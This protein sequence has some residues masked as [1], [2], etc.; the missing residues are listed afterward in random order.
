MNREILERF[1]NN[2]ASEAEVEE[3]LKWFEDQELDPQKSQSLEE[4]WHE[5]DASD[6]V[7]HD[8]EQLLNDI[9]RDIRRSGVRHGDK[10]LYR[11]SRTSRR[12]DYGFATWAKA[13]AVLVVAVGLFVFWSVN[14]GDTGQTV[15]EIKK[16]TKVA[17]PGE[18][19]TLTLSD[20]TVIQLNSDS[21]IT[22]PEKFS[23]TEREV[24]LTGEAFFEVTEDSSRRFVVHTGELTTTVL[25]TSFNIRN[26][27]GDELTDISL[28][29][30]KLKVE[31]SD[32]SSAL[33]S[34]VLR[35]G[36]AAVLD[37]RERS[38]SKI[39]FDARDKYGWTN[40]ILVF[41]D[42]NIDETI[43]KIE[44]WY[45]VT[46]KIENDGKTVK[47]KWKY[48]GIFQ[49]ESLENVLKGISYIKGFTYEIKNQRV[50]II[51]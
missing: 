46:I 20:G 42:T 15:E 47:P 13:A 44:R 30:G 7:T 40:G 9:H 27:E 2:E 22:F 4:L 11:Y 36:E 43:T 26:Y 16:I 19:K 24:F 17:E 12:R 1:F 5:I 25:G 38:F 6:Y 28:A 51:F 29:S 35:P 49:D 33:K 3:V 32:S 23:K 48:R 45:G 37:K 34:Y 39:R 18:K 14:N 8:E 50:K 10:R 21:R 41:R 31:S